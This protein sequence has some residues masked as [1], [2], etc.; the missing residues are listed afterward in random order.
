MSDS[1]FPH[2]SDAAPPQNI[3]NSISQSEQSIDGAHNQ[4]IGEATDSNIFYFGNEGQ[5]INININDRISVDAAF[6]PV[7]PAT[8][9]NREEHRDRMTLISRVKQFWIKGVLKTSLHDRV[10]LKLGLQERLDLTQKTFNDPCGLLSTNGQSLPNNTLIT[11]IFD[12]MEVARTILIVG[13]PGSGKTITLLKLAEDLISRA[14]QDLSQPIPVVLNLSSWSSKK[15]TIER[16]LIQELS[17]KYQVP[18]NLGEK[19]IKTE[20]LILL[21]DGLDEVQLGKRDGC[22]QALNQ[23]IHGHHKTEIAVCSRLQD[24]QDLSEKLLLRTAIC[25]QP[26]TSEQVSHYFDSVGISLSAL[27]IAVQRDRNLQKLAESPLMLSIMSLTYQGDRT[28]ELEKFN[29]IENYYDELFK[30]YIERMFHRERGNK[31]YSKDTSI[32]WLTWIA[33]QLKRESKTI[34]LI[35]RIT[36][37]F[38]SINSHRALYATL[39]GLGMATLLSIVLG[40]AS[41]FNKIFFII[42]PVFWVLT[43][44]TWGIHQ[45]RMQT[46]ETLQWSIDSLKS[47]FWG[48]CIG[49]LFLIIVSSSLMGLFSGFI[50]AIACL[51]IALFLFGMLENQIKNHTE[52]NQAIWSSLKNGLLIGCAGIGSIIIFCLIVGIPPSRFAFIGFTFGLVQGLPGC[53][54]HFS[55][56]LIFYFSGYCPWNYSKFLDYATEKLFLQKVGGGYIFVHRMLLE[57][58]AKMTF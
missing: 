20:S 33:Q 41:D 36:S 24:Y 54:Q 53:V 23:F 55:L 45:Q 31:S 27:K 26:L 39:H 49:F 9:I 19:L 2:N 56:R 3:D 25:V 38:I 52:T 28:V 37:S 29:T 35:D 17:E 21:L 11:E 51:T 7:K 16:W 6:P 10:F 34:F 15:I 12:Q 46:L 22:V 57:H 13:E 44:L 5:V 8:W 18:S 58:F 4:T 14:E 48:M 43:G 42:F 50:F 47:N 30:N 40:L 1:L 32:C